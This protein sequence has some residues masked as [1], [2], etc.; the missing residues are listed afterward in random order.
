VNGCFRAIRHSINPSLPSPK[1]GRPPAVSQSVIAKAIAIAAERDVNLNSCTCSE[2][3]MDIVNAIQE[4]RDM[5]L[6][7]YVTLP[8]FSQS[9]IGKIVRQITPIRVRNG[10][11]LYIEV[12]EEDNAFDSHS[13]YFFNL[14][15]YKIPLNYYIINGIIKDTN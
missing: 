10:R 3:V 11:V 4:L 6:N 14:L 8:S 15:I 13:T 12:S 5:G 2:D 9:T 1:R 7:P